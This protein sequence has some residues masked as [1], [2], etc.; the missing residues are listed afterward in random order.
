MSAQL[1]STSQDQTMIL[2]LSNP[3]LRNALTTDICAAGIEALSVAETSPDIRCVIITGEGAN[4]CAGSDVHHLHQQIQKGSQAQAQMVESVHNWMEAIRT[5]PKPVIAAVE[6]A[7]VGAGFSLALVCDLI[8]AA[9]DSVFM[10]GY[11]NLGLSPYGGASWNLAQSLPRQTAMALLLLDER[12]SADR[13]QGLGLVNHVSDRGHAVREALALA[14]RLS[15]RAPNAMSSI[16]ELINEVPNHHLTAH[17]NA[18]RQA[19]VKN[20]LHPNARSGI[21]AFLSKQTPTYK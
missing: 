19:F 6:G 9:S 10:S 1:K 4:F 2:T 16:K 7:C 12:L 15:A 11:S 21:E 13:M 17:L 18:E 14:Q 3:A 5:F 8:L 20:L